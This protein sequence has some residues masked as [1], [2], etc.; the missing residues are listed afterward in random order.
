MVSG[1]QRKPSAVA[2]GWWVVGCGGQVRTGQDRTKLLPVA[3]QLHRMTIGESW[4]KLLGGKNERAIER[5]R[6]M[7][8]AF[9][10]ECVNQAGEKNRP[11]W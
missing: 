4:K 11:D 10:I 6:R 7:T 8:R 9:I 1:Q 3:L 2:E 5:R